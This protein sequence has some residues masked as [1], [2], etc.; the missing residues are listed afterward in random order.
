[1]NQDPTWLMIC[2]GWIIFCG[3]FLLFTYIKFDNSK[4][5]NKIGQFVI[6][7][8]FIKRDKKILISYG[9]IF[10]FVGVMVMLVTY[11]KWQYRG[12]P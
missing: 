2:S 1:M 7:F 9:F 12:A 8:S 6:D 11:A 10:V 3:M 5:F 4:I